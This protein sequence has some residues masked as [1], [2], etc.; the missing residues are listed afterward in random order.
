MDGTEEYDV[1][2][3]R[4]ECRMRVKLRKIVKLYQMECFSFEY[5]N[6]FNHEVWLLFI[7]RSCLLC[8]TRPGNSFFDVFFSFSL[9]F[10]T[11]ALYYNSMAPVIPIK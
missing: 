7:C 5:N 10:L 6:Y 2:V 1:E 8:I 9:T 4:S 3:I 11:L